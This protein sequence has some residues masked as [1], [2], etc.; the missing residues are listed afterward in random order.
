MVE[1]ASEVDFRPNGDVDLDNA[2]LRIIDQ[3][4]RNGRTNSRAMVESTG[5]TEETVGTR[6]RNLVDR[7][8]I[9]ITA[10]FDWYAAGYHWDF[11][12]VIKCEPGPVEVVSRDLV[13]LDETVSVQRVFGHADLIAHVFCT[14]RSHLETFLSATLPCIA[15]VRHA[16]VLLSVD[17]VKSLYQ[18]AWVPAKDEPLR[19]PDP[20]VPLDALDHG[21]IAAVIRNGRT[22][23]REISRN[24][25]VSDATIR[26]RLRRLE[27]A[28]LL[29]IC[30]QIHPS[31]SGMVGARA[32][33]GVEVHQLSA[34]EVAIALARVPQAVS[35]SLTSG[36]YHVFCYL[37]ASSHQ[38]LVEVVEGQIRSQPGVRSIEVLPVIERTL[39]HGT[40]WARW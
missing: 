30:A 16:D 7:G 12:L 3:L 27:E 6:I 11:W 4:V 19:F 24:L 37:L 15:G 31:R 38:Q 13:A 22:S 26:L 36:R 2:D 17:T 33:V 40:H 28:G 1:F 10:I 5:L 9:D 39:K 29:R 34:E 32:W 25:S 20:V 18:F 23:N 8:I 35:V 14:D 21:I